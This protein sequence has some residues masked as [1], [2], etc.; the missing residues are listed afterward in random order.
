MKRAEGAGSRQYLSDKGVR[1]IGWAAKDL[2]SKKETDSTEEP[3][4]MTCDRDLC[5]GCGVCTTTCPTGAMALKLRGEPVNPPSLDQ[6]L[7]ARY[8]KEAVL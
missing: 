7:A 1:D 4:K 3:D 5:I 6:F 8:K 2:F